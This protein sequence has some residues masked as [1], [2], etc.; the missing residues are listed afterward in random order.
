MWLSNRLLSN[1]SSSEFMY[2][3][4]VSHTHR[5]YIVAKPEKGRRVVKAVQCGQKNSLVL[6]YKF[7]VASNIV[8]TGGPPLTRKSLTQSPTSAVLAYVP[9]S[10]GF[11][12]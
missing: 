6:F 4:V 11:S 8:G 7:K 1:P 12:R 3:P 5:Q 10:G 9:A 2:A